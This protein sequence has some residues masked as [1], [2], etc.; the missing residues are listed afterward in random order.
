MESGSRSVVVVGAVAVLLVLAGCSGSPGDG[1]PSTTEYHEPASESLLSAEQFT[2]WEANGTRAPGA[3]PAGME[4]GRVL[5]LQNGS[6]NLQIALLVFESPADARAFLAA[7]RETY[8]GDGINTTNASVGD[9]A[10]ATTSLTE[11]AVDAQQSN[12]YVQV[13]GAVPLNASQQYARAQLRAV[14]DR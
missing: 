6:A 11:T 1:T 7:Q 2:N 8:E 9:R 4:S 3:A 12:V 5:E 10:F 13:T 14:T